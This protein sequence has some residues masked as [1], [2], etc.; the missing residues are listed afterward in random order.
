MKKLTTLPL[1]ALFVF[2]ATFPAAAEHIYIAQTARGANTGA[3][4]ANAHG[5]TWFND[6][7]NWS[8]IVA[9]DGKIGPGDTVHLTGTINNQLS[10]QGSGTT[11][12]RI[13]IK[14][15]PGAKMSAPSWTGTGAIYGGEVA[16]MTIEGGNPGP[17]KTT[18]TQVDM[19][20]TQNGTALPSKWT[21]HDSFSS[22][23][24]TT[25]HSGTFG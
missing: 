25:S 7:G 15:D 20:A 14:F 19:E 13:T 3:D 1:A 8:A 4:A 9:N 2:L 22:R 16:N 23:T 18:F 6:D 5:Y 21:V 10:I 24:E 12:N 11:S 17:V